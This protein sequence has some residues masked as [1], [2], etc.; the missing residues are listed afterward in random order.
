MILGLDIS[1][2]VVGWCILNDDGS[3]VDVGYLDLKKYKSLY[4]KLGPFEEL[5]DSLHSRP[6]PGGYR[7]FVEAPLG[8]SNNQHVVNLLQRWNGMC[9][10]YIYKKFNQEPTLTPPKTAVKDFGITVPKGVKGE[11]RKKYIL[12]C[13]KAT[14][15]IP[16]D[17]W[18]LN[19]NGN[20]H[21]WCYDQADSY[22]VACGGVQ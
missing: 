13:V 6:F 15:T 17:K 10:A 2:S 22:I 12:E 7:V 5:M 11:N 9:C 16:I 14:N 3:Y 4:D 19:R 1:S 18:G 21:K 20:P 8:R